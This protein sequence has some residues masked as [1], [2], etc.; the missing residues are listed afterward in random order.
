MS[1]PPSTAAACS[2]SLH[3]AAAAP[4]AAS[5][6]CSHQPDPASGQKSPNSSEATSSP[7]ARD[8]TQRTGRP[9][10][11]IPAQTAQYLC[12]KDASSDF[13]KTLIEEAA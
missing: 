1:G 2:G 5:G 7:E 10:F 9:R 13:R 4:P 3:Q 12:T 8:A 6:S 11:R